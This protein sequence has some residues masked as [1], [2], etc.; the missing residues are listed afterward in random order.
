MKKFA[1]SI[2]SVTLVEIDIT[3]I[4]IRMTTV[5]PLSHSNLMVIVFLLINVRDT[6][7]DL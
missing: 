7:E 5:Q 3:A 2:L 1:K 6:Q 4:I